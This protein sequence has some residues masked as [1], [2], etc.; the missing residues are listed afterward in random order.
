M[1]SVSPLAH[2]RGGA[3]EV[4][5]SLREQWRAAVQ[6]MLGTALSVVC[7]NGPWN[8]LSGSSSA[9]QTGFKCPRLCL[10]VSGAFGVSAGSIPAD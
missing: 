5:T 4:R 2:G 6:T 8:L 10:A 7:G 3:G 9:G 1:T